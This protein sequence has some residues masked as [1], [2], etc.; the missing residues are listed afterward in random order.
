[1][2]HDHYVGSGGQS[3]TVTGLLIPAV[4]VITVVNEADKA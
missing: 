2:E 3:F 1:M 4:S